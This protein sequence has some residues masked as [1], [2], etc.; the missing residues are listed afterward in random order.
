[1]PDGKGKELLEKICTVCHDLE[2]V[3]S[4]HTTKKSWEDTLDEMVTL[5]ADGSKDEMQ[6]I[7]NYVAKYFGPSVDVIGIGAAV[8]R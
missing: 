4:N 3:A 2:R 6:T 1:M 5:G 7:L 8:A